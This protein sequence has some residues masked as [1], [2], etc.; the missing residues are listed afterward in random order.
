MK[1]TM[2]KLLT[3]DLNKFMKI[4]LVVK[5]KQNNDVFEFSNEKLNIAAVI[6]SNNIKDAQ[7]RY[8]NFVTDTIIE[9]AKDEILDKVFESAGIRLRQGKELYDELN[10]EAKKELDKEKAMI[11]NKKESI[12]F[13]DATNINNIIDMSL[14]NPYSWAI[15]PA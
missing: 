10:K 11:F 14:S 5:I 2:I 9:Y 8:A 1:N 15:Q 4:M 7:E 6:E 3:L 12:P 13:S